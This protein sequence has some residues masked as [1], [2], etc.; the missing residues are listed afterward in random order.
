MDPKPEAVSKTT[1]PIILERKLRGEKITCLTA[2]D[3]PTARLVDESGVDM[4]L[5]GDSLA[6]VVLGYDSTI[7]VTLDEMLHHLRAVRRAVRR[8][9]LIVDLPYGSY[10]QGEKEAL[11]AGVRC[12]KEGA[13]AVKLE[14]GSKRTTL[15]RRLVEAE[16]PVMGHI[17]LT[18]QS[19]HSF[20]GYRVQGRTLESASDLLADAQAVEDAGAFAL[21]LEGIPRELAGLITGRLRIPT[22]G[23][24]AGPDCDGQVLVIHDLLGLA[25]HPTPK[26]VRTYAQLAGVIRN[27][28]AQ[29]RED[30]AAGRFPAD[31]ESY[32]WS[33]GLQEQ[34]AKWATIRNLKGEG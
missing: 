5:V 8:A 18:P 15:I 3:Y 10:H 26:F 27:A 25:L 6:Q 4:I 9:L 7:P 13:E 19:V 29:Y 23:I 12:L 17:G 11:R 16:I 33:P 32:H 34:F 20:G 30:V 14:G 21:V 22:I 28:L 24:G 31:A 1:V 2:Y